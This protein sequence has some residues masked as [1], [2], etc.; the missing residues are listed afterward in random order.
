MAS[1]CSLVESGESLELAWF[2]NEDPVTRAAASGSGSHSFTQILV[3]MPIQFRC[4]YCRQ[5]LGISRSRAGSFVDCPAC[6]RSLRVP[7]EDGSKGPPEPLKRPST[8]AKFLDAL[9]EL[10]GLSSSTGSVKPAAPP[11]PVA[12]KKR[13]SPHGALADVGRTR[14]TMRIVPLPVATTETV[15]PTDVLQELANLPSA[16]DDIPLILPEILSDQTTE[17][18]DFP[19]DQSDS[20]REEFAEFPGDSEMGSTRL[21]PELSHALFELAQQPPLPS[22]ATSVRPRRTWWPM[23]LALTGV[24]A[25]AA[26]YLV[27]HQ[28][29][30]PAAIE[31]AGGM[32]TGPEAGEAKDIPRIAIEPKSP[33]GLQVV[34]G[35]VTYTSGPGLTAPDAGALVLLLPLTNSAGLKMDAGPL[36][37]PEETLAQSAVAAAMRILGASFVRTD[38]NGNF[39]LERT[40]PAPAALLVI[41]RH[42]AREA[43][44]LVSSEIEGL[45]G[46]WFE[47]GLRLIGRLAVQQRPLSGL[48][49]GQTDDQIIDVSFGQSTAR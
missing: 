44:G 29:T 7:Q 2:Q 20:K 27:A 4:Q 18:D 42:A 10:S 13:E 47:S 22:A 24:L 39:Q 9:E 21:P 16:D 36:R 25:F 26:G 38:S 32:S 23:W 17:S 43:S 6:G 41:S 14:D 31:T 48:S 45:L 46:I 5:L 12:A 8:D 3:R 35:V 40:S 33:E 11:P 30:G 15:S 1:F 28:L 49:D 37:D 34:R 19:D